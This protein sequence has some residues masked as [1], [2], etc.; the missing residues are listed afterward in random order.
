[1]QLENAEINWFKVSAKSAEKRYD[2]AD[3]QVH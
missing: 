3:V 2:Q 1:M